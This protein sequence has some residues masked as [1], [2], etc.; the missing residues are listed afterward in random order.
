[1]FS[2]CYGPVKSCSQPCFPLS[3]CCLKL[4]CSQPS[5]AEVSH[6]QVQ[7]TSNL[8]FSIRGWKLAD[9]DGQQYALFYTIL[10][11]GFG[12]SQILVLVE[13]LGPILHRYRETTVLTI[14]GK[15]TTFWAGLKEQFI[16]NILS[17]K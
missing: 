13:V 11:K 9:A 6:P 16:L 2:F 5:I 15:A 1:M 4:K 10:Y 14:F 3:L 12:H 8:V 7:T 17:R